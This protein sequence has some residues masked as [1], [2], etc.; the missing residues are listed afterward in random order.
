MIGASL[1]FRYVKKT[2]KNTVRKE[3]W[4]N[5]LKTFENS[6]W[7]C[8]WTCICNSPNIYFTKYILKLYF[9][10]MHSDSLKIICT[11]K[12]KIYTYIKFMSQNVFKKNILYLWHYPTP[13]RLDRHVRFLYTLYNNLCTLWKSLVNNGL[14]KLGKFLKNI[15]SFMIK[16]PLK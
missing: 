4:E 5:I 15:N 12:K 16:F 14:Y 2:A 11:Y 3:K 10:K 6:L 1:R 8:V 13:K 7:K 9:N